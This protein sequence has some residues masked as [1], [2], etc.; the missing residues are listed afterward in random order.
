MGK[1]LRSWP[2][3]ILAWHTS[4]VTNGPTE[5]MNNLIKRIKRMAPAMTNFVNLSVRALLA[6]HKPNWA[7]LSTV[8]PTTAIRRSLVS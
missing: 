1:T 5:S 8:H 3:V 4:G 6:A 2:N 7:H